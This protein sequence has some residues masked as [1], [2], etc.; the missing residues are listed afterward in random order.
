MASF[1]PVAGKAA[2]VVFR[3]WQQALM[4]LGAGYSGIIPVISGDKGLQIPSRVAVFINPNGADFDT[5]GGI[6]N[7]D[8]RGGS[9]NCNPGVPVMVDFARWR[10]GTDYRQGKFCKSQHVSSETPS[11]LTAGKCGHTIIS[12]VALNFRSG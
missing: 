10:A 1:L 11:W 2:T 9:L 4:G 3:V 7:L 6:K 12:F 5:A 8:H